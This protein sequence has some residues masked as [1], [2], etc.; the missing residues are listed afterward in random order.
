M[1]A[2]RDVSFF[3]LR[4][5]QVVDYDIWSRPTTPKNHVSRASEPRA[6]CFHRQ[7]RR[8]QWKHF[9]RWDR[10]A[11]CAIPGLRSN[12]CYAAIPVHHAHVDCV[13][14]SELGVSTH[15]S[16]HVRWSSPGQ[17]P[18]ER[19][20]ESLICVVHLILRIRAKDIQPDEACLQHVLP[21]CFQQAR[22]GDRTIVLLM[23]ASHPRLQGIAHP[24]PACRIVVFAPVLLNH[25]Y[26]LL[27]MT[28]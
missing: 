24:G 25:R 16:A 5:E 28:D 15:P 13:C 11:R 20:Q 19:D 2:D 14:P 21:G 9:V 12:A 10:D 4:A 22:R 3:A 1:Q 26:I 8:R 17:I 27:T 7:G 18:P 6:Q 23:C